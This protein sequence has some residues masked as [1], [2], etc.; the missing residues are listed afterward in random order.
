MFII[1]FAINGLGG[2]NRSPSSRKA[3]MKKCL[4]LTGVSWILLTAIYL[5]L[6]FGQGFGSHRTEVREGDP[7]LTFISFNLQTEIA[8]GDLV[9]GIIFFK[10]TEPLEADLKVFFHLT[11]PGQNQTVLNADFSPRY[12]TRLWDVNQIV[13]AGPFELAIPFSVEPGEYD[14]RAGLLQV[15]REE[16]IVRYVREPYTN[17]DIENFTIGKVTVKETE[18]PEPAGPSEYDLI[19]F[20]NEAEIIYWETLGAKVEFM[21]YSE[22]GAGSV[23][24]ARI[25]ILPGMAEYPGV[26]LQN[27]FQLQPSRADW[28]LYDTLRLNIFIPP[29]SRGGGLVLKITDRSGRAYQTRLSLTPGQTERFDLNTI[30]LSGSINVSA[31]SQIKFFLVNPSSSFTAGGPGPGRAGPPLSGQGLLQSLPADL[32]PAQDVRPRLPGQRYGRPDRH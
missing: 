3:E 7:R 18:V 1:P 19:A 23:S 25:T 24:A 20:D 11:R 5:P 22:E 14:I 26:I 12:P 17:T 29:E 4:F 13:E 30:D 9:R 27:F 2:F 15:V 6:L 21:G 10:V 16:D 28:S 31:I 32:P 8:Q